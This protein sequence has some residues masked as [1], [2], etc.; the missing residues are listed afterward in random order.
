MTGLGGAE[1]CYLGGL[2]FGGCRM[3]SFVSLRH[4][5]DACDTTE[6]TCWAP[7]GLLGPSSCF[8]RPGACSGA[9]AQPD[10]C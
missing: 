9:E 6:N 5:R 4:V 7:R 10:T 3:P 8:L 1:S 2:G